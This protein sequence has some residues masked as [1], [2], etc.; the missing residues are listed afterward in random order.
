MGD[1]IQLYMEDWLY[2]SGLVGF[3]NILKNSE[4]DVVI[5][6]NYLEFDSDCL[7]EIEK[8]YFDYFIK[9][10][11]DI[12]SLNKIISFE[13]S[14]SYHEEKGFEEFD[15]KSLE[16]TN[17]YISKVVKKQVKSNS[18]KS[19]YNL[20]GSSVD[21]LGLEKKLKKIK[22]NKKQEIKD[23]LPEIEEKFNLLKQIIEYM[24]LEESKKYIGAKNVMYTVI[25][26]GW[27]GVCFLNPQTK[28]KDM[29]IDYNNYFVQPVIDYLQEDESKY[30][31]SCFS[32]GRKMNNF[33]NDLSFLNSTGFDVSRKSSH[34]WDFQNDVAVC[35]ICKLIYSCVPA[36]IT[37][38]YNK[39]IYVN[40]NSSMKNAININTKIYMG[41]FKQ[42]NEGKRLTYK[43][44][45]ESINEEY[46][47]KIKYELADIQLV[48]YEDE[49]Y[50][51]NILSRKSLEII[52]DSK[53]DLNKL[54][55]CGF[56]E[57]NTYFNVYELVID[58]LLNSQNMFTLI[59]KLLHYKLS[60]P[61]DCY[62]NSYH[63]IRLL[64][65]NTS[66]L[67]RVGYM[68][69]LDKD[70]D[71]V[72]LGNNAGYYLRRDY[73]DSVDKLSGISYRLLN[74]LKTNNADSFMDTLLNCYLYVKKPV[75]KVFLDT[76]RSEEK[77]KTIGYAFV[78]GLIDEKKD[79][80]G[81][82]NDE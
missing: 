38:F 79:K 47:D 73:G 65:I 22:L 72:E 53:N 34:V 69:D 23:I 77:F 59:Q 43:A 48:R 15:K 68:K 12:L 17:E 52:K 29:Y 41:I 24:K 63:I 14:I 42:N 5:N 13:D 21:I 50:R 8:K 81:G 1:K 36:G 27:N 28:E 4:D 45:V 9:K 11:K 74:S 80:N 70:K 40:D 66:F 31:F 75:P 51:F 57:I 32:C 18:Y 67:R 56:R 19:A 37:Y 30:K 2:N 54:V 64:N 49:K 35:P 25:N 55:N 3:Y 82:N 7:I 78:S 33:S 76:L 62:Y 39:G 46:N 44:L 71:I 26:N 61:K 58:R 16:Y 6:Q 10:Y 60:Q 20:I